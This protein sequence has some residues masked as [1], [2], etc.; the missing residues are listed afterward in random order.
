MLLQKLEAAEDSDPSQQFCE[1]VQL[2]GK[3]WLP[4]LLGSVMFQCSCPKAE[5]FEMAHLKANLK[6][7]ATDKCELVKSPLFPE[8]PNKM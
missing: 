7:L 1:S 2:L 6:R 4:M 8:Q 3:C 5:Y